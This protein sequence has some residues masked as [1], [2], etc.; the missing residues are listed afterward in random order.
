MLVTIGR[1]RLLRRRLICVPIG[2]FCG[3][4][5]SGAFLHDAVPLA[6]ARL[7]SL[8]LADPA[9]HDPRA[10]DAAGPR[11]R[12]SGRGALRPGRA[13]SARGSSC[14]TAGWG[15][16]APGASG[17]PLRPARRDRGEPGSARA[18]PGGSATHRAR[19]GAGRG[20]RVAARPGR[21]RAGCS[22]SPL[23]RA[24]PRPTRSPAAGRRGRRRRAASSSSTTASGTCG[25]ADLPPEDLARWRTDPSFAPPGG[26]SLRAVARGSR[27]CAPTSRTGHRRRGQ[28]RLADQG[29]RTWALDADQ[30]LAWRMFLDLASITASPAS[31]VGTHRIQRHGASRLR[32]AGAAL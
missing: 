24:R 6:A 14:A 2:W 27:R 13:G 17:D 3:L 23:A 26:E 5:L 9:G 10:R 18:R 31:A 29:R 21:E 4:V 19:P 22:R 7:T 11:A 8:R 15:R 30:L 1:P 20:A 12:A 25:F 32:R 16:S 28:P